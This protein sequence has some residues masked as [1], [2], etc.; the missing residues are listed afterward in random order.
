MN[1]EF[2]IKDVDNLVSKPS[3][4]NYTI[5]TS[6]L[7][8]L[9]CYCCILATH[10]HCTVNAV[11]IHAFVTVT[12]YPNICCK[13]FLLSKMEFKM[14]RHNFCNIMETQHTP[15]ILLTSNERCLQ[16][17]SQVWHKHWKGSV[18]AQGHTVTMYYYQ[19][20]A[21]TNCIL[22]TLP[23]RSFISDFHLLYLMYM[24]IT[25]I[26]YYISSHENF[27][28]LLACNVI[29]AWYHSH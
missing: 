5:L 17:A 10:S 1:H 29:W 2:T 27:N 14:K 20:N 22:F 9:L 18:V 15:Q 7:N 8:M 24:C 6:N 12:A 25:Y 28:C 21:A 13:F 23:F 16:G 19:E 3:Q 11:F 4:I 26:M